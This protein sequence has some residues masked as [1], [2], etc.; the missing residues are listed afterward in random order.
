MQQVKRLRAAVKARKAA[1]NARNRQ[2]A[3]VRERAGCTLV[4]E[5]QR[6]DF[7]LFLRKPQGWVESYQ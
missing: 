1:D 6:C 2:L 4:L 5:N 7:S 3:G